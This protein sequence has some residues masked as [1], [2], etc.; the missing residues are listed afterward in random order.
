LYFPL[1]LQQTHFQSRK[2]V[3]PLINEK[4]HEKRVDTFIKLKW[5]FSAFLR[6]VPSCP[7]QKRGPC[8]N[9]LA[10][11]SKKNRLQLQLEWKAETQSKNTNFSKWKARKNKCWR[12]QL[13]AA[14][15]FVFACT[16]QLPQNAPRRSEREG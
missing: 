13:A 12:L 10:K 15:A 5:I 7:D 1:F 16:L 4:P 14:S 9:L 2:F 3:L 11:K 8:N 6:Y